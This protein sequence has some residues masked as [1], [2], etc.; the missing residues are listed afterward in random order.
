MKVF[1]S[2]RA[3]GAAMLVLV[4]LGVAVLRTGGWG[5]RSPSFPPQA[6]I[7][8]AAEAGPSPLHRVETDPPARREVAVEG[9]GG[10][11]AR[12]G[13][14]LRGRVVDEQGRGIGGARV[15]AWSPDA[16]PEHNPAA[17]SLGSTVS[18][19]EGGFELVLP[20]MAPATVLLGVEAS[21]YEEAVLRVSPGRFVTIRLFPRRRSARLAGRVL[22]E[23]GGPVPAFRL[24]WNSAALAEVSDPD[25]RFDV[26]VPLDVPPGAAGSQ[27]AAEGRLTVTGRL[28]T[29][30]DV[31][32]RLRPGEERTDLEIR[33]GRARS[34]AGEV[35]DP[36]GA[37]VP[38]ARV[39]PW[40][41]GVWGPYRADDRSETTDEQGRFALEIPSGRALEGVSVAA[42]GFA[43]LRCVGSAELDRRT[44]VGGR[45]RLVLRP[46]TVVTGRVR[47]RD[48]S[49][50]GGAQ[51]VC[52]P[53]PAVDA[54]GAWMPWGRLS[55]LR[56][57][58]G[59]GGAP[60]APDPVRA[61]PDGFFAVEHV[62]PG[63]W[64][65]FAESPPGGGSWRSPLRV[66]EVPEGASA[67]LDAGE[68]VLD[69]GRVLTV[70][71]DLSSWPLFPDAPDRHDRDRPDAEA[72]EVPVPAGAVFVEGRLYL[73]TPA[74]SEA[75]RVPIDQ[76]AAPGPQAVFRFRIPHDVPAGP[77]TLR[78][79]VN[80]GAFVER[81]VDDPGFDAEVALEFGL[82]DAVWLLGGRS[83][84]G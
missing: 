77:K 65:F 69:G 21:G 54:P 15:T 13:P 18:A 61:D 48:G 66:V 36:S 81:R 30:R 42:E 67:A 37:A 51:V 70:R 23:D 76:C 17:S 84:G 59:R 63:R 64:V 14:R 5:G 72:D 83:Q 78:L 47:W 19:P 44:D 8:G 55:L 71:C 24:S 16:L 28:V 57:E 58:Y 46:G 62:A 43:P 80:P 11:E 68:L 39:T 53:L 49:A 56:S 73:G 38:G 79:L 50:A 3:V 35:V 1:A 2:R 45:L 12:T 7:E 75:G 9:D 52:A 40:L 4:L 33:V 6:R 74:E 27:V 22:F 20:A 29:R 82:E 10:K 32:L 31:S 26:E 60:D 41:D 34:V 25:G